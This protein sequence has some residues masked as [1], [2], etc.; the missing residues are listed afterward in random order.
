MKSKMAGPSKGGW[1]HNMNQNSVIVV[2]ILRPL[3]YPNWRFFVAGI[4]QCFSNTQMA[5]PKKTKKVEKNSKR[6]TSHKSHFQ[7]L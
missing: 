1:G 5:Y 3:V 7:R 2:L 4:P 6:R